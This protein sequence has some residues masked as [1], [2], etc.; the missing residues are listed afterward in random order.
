MFH[1]GQKV[2]CISDAIDDDEPGPYVFKGKVYTINDILNEYGD[3]TLTFHELPIIRVR[4]WSYGYSAEN[5]RP[6]VEKKTDISDFRKIL[7]RVKE[8]L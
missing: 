2:I 6:V 8:Y 4:G 1:I 5:F 3:T 7:D